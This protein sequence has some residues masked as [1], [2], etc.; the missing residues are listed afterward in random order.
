MKTNTELST[1]Y[2][3]LVGKGEQNRSYSQ[4]YKAVLRVQKQ[5][6]SVLTD[7]YSSPNPKLYL[8]STQNSKMRNK[9]K[10]GIKKSQTLSLSP[11]YFRNK[12]MKHILDWRNR[13]FED[14]ILIKLITRLWGDNL[15]KTLK[16]KAKDHNW[17]ETETKFCQECYLK[18]TKKYILS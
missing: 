13:D 18:A 5:A 16:N 10:T 14:P 8:R 15:L 7:F 11:T 4:D 3:K 9:P 6:L 12:K 1:L 17:L 2:T